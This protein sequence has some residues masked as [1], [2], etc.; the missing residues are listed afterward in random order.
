MHAHLLLRRSKALSA[1]ANAPA[2]AVLHVTSRSGATVTAA[3]TAAGRALSTLA[4]LPKLHA[5]IPEDLTSIQRL[6]NEYEVRA[7]ALRSVV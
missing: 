7:R 5:S 6:V 2:A 1:R 3:S 4:Y